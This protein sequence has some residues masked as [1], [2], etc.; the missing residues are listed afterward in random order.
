MEIPYWLEDIA[1]TT[2]YNIMEHQ[3][4]KKIQFELFGYIIFFSTRKIPKTQWC[5]SLFVSDYLIL[6]L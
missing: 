2:L 5:N 4:K 3:I 6:H 1:Y